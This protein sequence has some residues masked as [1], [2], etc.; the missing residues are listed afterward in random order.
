VGTEAVSLN[1]KQHRHEFDRSSRSNAEVKYD[2]AYAFTH[3]SNFMAQFSN[4]NEDINFFS[5][6][7]FYDAS[8]SMLHTI[9]KV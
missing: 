7:Y 6:N 9:K 8:V 2:G 4:K 5:V 3:T 1:V